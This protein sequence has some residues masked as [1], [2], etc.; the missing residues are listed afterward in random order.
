MFLKRSKEE[1]ILLMLCGLS[2]PSILPFGIIRL[3]QNNLLLAAV[4]L[5]IVTGMLCIMLF[6]WRTRRI[7]L[8]GIAVTVF[9]SLGMLAAIYLKGPGIVYWVYPTMIAAFFILKAKEAL[10]IN[11]VSLLLLVGILHAKMSL[12]DLSTLIVT[13]ILINLFSYIFSHRTSLQHHELN[14][15]AEKDFL[16]GVGNRRAFD[17]KLQDICDD[18][19]PHKDAC[20]LILD[21]DHF[22]NV[23]DQFGHTVGDD[24]LIQFCAL[25]RARIRSIDSLFRYG[26]EEFVV[27]AIGTDS[28]AAAR[29]AEELRVLIEKA[30]LIRDY[31]VTVSIGVARK[32]DGESSADWFQRADAMLYDAKLSGRN[33]VRVAA[34]RDELA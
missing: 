2:I 30:I 25:L 18:S 15:Q 11:S 13:L 10:A 26:G 9:Y 33:A 21:L 22:K 6:V 12:L 23:N 24:V 14:Q 28:I 3:F 34:D 17:R 29:F 31:P 19:S 1:V 20:L 8:A 7:R 32:C 4:D 27:V 5:L 16:T